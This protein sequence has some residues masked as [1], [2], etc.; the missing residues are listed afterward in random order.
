MNVDT[1]RDEWIF[2]VVFCVMVFVIPVLVVWATY[3]EK[4]RLDVRSLWTNSADKLD[5]FAV[6]LIGTWWVHTCS[7]VMWTL[8]LTVQ[9]QDY[10]TYMGWGIPIVVKMFAPNGAPPAPATPPKAPTP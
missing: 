8:L 9:T 2:L 7:M 6:I 3:C 10:V 5:R 1:V 4:C